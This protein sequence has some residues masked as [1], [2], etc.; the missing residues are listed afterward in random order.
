MERKY[1]DMYQ[2]L[3]DQRKQIVTGE[4]EPTD[5]EKVKKYTEEEEE[6]EDEEV[7]EKMKQIAIDYPE[8][9]KGV[10]E[11]WLTIF[12]CTDL[13]SQMVQKCDEPVLKKLIDIKTVYNTTE[14]SP[15]SF[16]LEFHFEQNEF[17][18]NTIL[19]KQYFLKS[20]IDKENPF[21]FEGPEI[22]K[23]TVIIV[24]CLWF[25]HLFIRCMFF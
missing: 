9:V 24:N 4:H 16:T 22:F 6:G 8:D 23:C 17:F 11:F 14:T 21:G 10:P 1:Q 18:T 20:D 15:M 7:T 5:A 3:N 12:R 19:T 2:T 25:V 13:L